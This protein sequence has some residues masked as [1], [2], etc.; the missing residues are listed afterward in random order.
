VVNVFKGIAYLFVINLPLFFEFKRISPP[1]PCPRHSPSPSR[2]HPN[3]ITGLLLTPLLPIDSR[4]NIMMKPQH[5]FLIISILYAHLPTGN[6]DPAYVSAFSVGSITTSIKRKQQFSGHVQVPILPRDTTTECIVLSSTSLCYTVNKEHH[7]SLLQTKRMQEA[8]LVE[9]TLS[10]SL[11]EARITH[12][13]NKRSTVPLFP[14]VR[15]CNAAIAT[16]GDSGDF[17]RALKM[18]TE[19][20]KSASIL[21]RILSSSGN[22]FSTMD[23]TNESSSLEWEENIELNDG[24]GQSSYLDLVEEVGVVYC[25]S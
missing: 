12:Y 18:F 15:Q 8:E 2:A 3:L 13:T 9:R 7:H 20:R 5:F 17:R 25:S 23:K 6:Q 4:L 22:L 16:F 1:A 14:S 10:N 21:R 24:G 11:H 19:M